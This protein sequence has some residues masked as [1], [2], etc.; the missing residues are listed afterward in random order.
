MTLDLIQ[1][2]ENEEEGQ[3]AEILTRELEESSDSLLP[4]CEAN[5]SIVI[6][7]TTYV[8]NAVFTVGPLRLIDKAP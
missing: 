5:R 8:H 3:Q 7:P 2:M 6:R 1:G 4:L